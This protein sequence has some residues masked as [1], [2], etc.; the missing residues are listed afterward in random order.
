MYS[1]FDETSAGVYPHAERQAALVVGNLRRNAL[2]LIRLGVC[3]VISQLVFFANSALATQITAFSYTSSQTSWVG[4]GQTVFVTP[5]DGFDFTVSHS[6]ANAISLFINDFAHNSDPF[7]T[8]WWHVDFAAPM[9]QLLQVDI[10][11]G[12]AEFPFQDSGQPGLNFDG[13]GRGNETLSGFFEVLQV[14]YGDNG[15]VLSFAA[16]F[17]QYDGRSIKAWNYGRIRYNS[18][19]PLTA[20]VPEP[21]SAALFCAGLAFVG[22]VRMLRRCSRGLACCTI[23]CTSFLGRANAQDD[24]NRFHAVQAWYGTLS[25]AGQ[26]SG[27]RTLKDGPSVTLVQTWNYSRTANASV[28]LGPEIKGA[29]WRGTIDGSA[30]IELLRTDTTTVLHP[31]GPTICTETF[32]ASG[33][34]PL[35]KNDS[36]FTL[37]PRDVEFTNATTY[38]FS[39]SSPF[40]TV[41]YT[42]THSG[43]CNPP[44]IEGDL[45]MDWFPTD[46]SIWTPF[47]LSGLDLVGSTKVQEFDLFPD[48]MDVTISWSFSPLPKDTGPEAV[49]DPC[50]KYGSIIGCQN[51]SLGQDMPLIG[52]G[53]FLHYESGR[54]PGRISANGVAVAHALMTAGW[55]LNIHHAYDVSSNTLFLG[56]GSQRSAWQLGSPPVSNGNTVLTN[57]DGDEVYLFDRVSA[58]H[59]QTLSALTGVRKYQFAYD[60]AGQLISATDENGN[61]TTIKRDASGIPT[62]IISPFSQTTTI[63]VDDNGFLSQAANPA[64]ST[65]RF[66]YDNTGLMTSRTDASGNMHHHIYDTLGRLTTD[67]DPADGATN[68]G[69]SH[70]GTGY[71]VTTTTAEGRAN[72]YQVTTGVFGQDFINT[73]PNGL[74]ATFKKVQQDGRLMTR[75]TLP[76]GTVQTETS[77][78]DPRWGLQA[79]TTALASL[80]LGNLTMT[81]SG[82]RQM[83]LGNASDLFSLHAQTDAAVVNGRRYT[84]TYSASNRTGIVTSPVGRK[85]VLTIN[86]RG[87]PIASQLGDLAPTNYF[88]DNRGH[89]VRVTQAAR[90]FELSYDSSGFLASVTDPLGLKETFTHDAAGRL[91]S[92]TFPDNRV[93]RFEYD[94]TG[95]LTAL[96]PPNNATHRFDYTPVDLYASYTPPLVTGD[97]TSTAYLYNADR[98]LTAIVRPDGVRI[99]YQYDNAG[100]LSSLIAPKTTINVAYEP[101]TGNLASLSVANGEATTYGYNGPLPVSV[102]WSGTVAGSVSRTYDNN[103]WVTSRSVNNQNLVPFAYDDDGLLRQ[104]GQV[105]LKRSLET[106]QIV[107]T[108]LDNATDT[109]LYNTFGEISGYSAQYGNV[110]AYSARYNRNNLGRIVAVFEEIAGTSHLYGYTFDAAGRLSGVSQNGISIA[111]YRYDSNSNRVTETTPSGVSNATYDAQDRL[112]TYGNSSYTHNANGE[113]SSKTQGGLVTKYL[114]DAFG[115]LAEVTLPSGITLRYIVDAENHRVAKTV[116][117][118]VVSGYLYDGANVV[119]V[120]GRNNQVI[121]RFVYGSTICPDYMV[122]DGVVYRIFSDHRG[123]PRLI[124]N[125]TT[126]VIAQQIDY[127]AFGRVLKDTNPGFQPFGFAG[128]LYDQDTQ[129]VHCGAREYDP[130]TG[131]W[132]SKDAIRFAGGDT[133]FYAYALNDPINMID[134]DGE[135]TQAAKLFNPESNAAKESSMLSKLSSGVEIAKEVV[136][137]VIERKVPKLV[138]D[139]VKDAAVDA[140]K[141]EP[142]KE[143]EK[144]VEEAEKTKPKVEDK[145]NVVKTIWK[146]VISQTCGDESTKKVKPH[147][148]SGKIEIKQWGK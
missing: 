11:Q 83:E 69:Q 67:S 14:L 141:R 24:P 63:S 136:D 65:D 50:E 142:R 148:K 33:T 144:L 5:S 53:L 118:N 41:P 85:R 131:R 26:S 70:S 106:G 99:E 146:V 107:S 119:A 16:D 140:A 32:R 29:G 93:V 49:D 64:G 101:V 4:G 138:D 109:R 36:G 115:N 90:T 127:D 22:F 73:W 43:D 19:I 3:F 78:P 100:R 62:A 46:T 133:N 9:N 81:R 8:Q 80:T 13:N 52:T 20:P 18:D 121:S 104:A 92:A 124:V 25:V 89:L 94:A 51:Q 135:Q 87:R 21:V 58:R 117:G 123:S 61:V 55:T 116:N 34:G 6:P 1:I 35:N 54:V 113:L 12:A 42:I 45:A 76:D 143:V 77:V 17:T 105:T 27:T 86:D 112:L 40:V 108:A 47:P 56:E 120:L 31:D 129:F 102:S 111:D 10:Y 23:V 91:L 59:I 74:Q 96:T 134:P 60:S 97:N 71:S 38:N 95:N 84:S 145:G 130:I 103:L 75:A 48:P 122:K 39:P 126:G 30:R 139:K 125:S 98:N 28:K 57:K 2:A 128:G 72:T 110:P 44:A 82:S 79:S 37:L 7:G 132:T 68:L 114:W 147:P 137:A 15:L 88:Y 66:T